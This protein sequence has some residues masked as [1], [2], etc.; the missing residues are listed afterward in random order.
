ML[1][2]LPDTL[3]PTKSFSGLPCMRDDGT[4]LFCLHSFQ[5]SRTAN[6]RAIATFATA[7]PRRNFNR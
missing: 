5:H 7:E 6:F 1:Y 4:A 2:Q 3:A